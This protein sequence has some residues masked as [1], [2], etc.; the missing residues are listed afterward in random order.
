[1]LVE[2][3]LVFFVEKEKE[4]EMGKE[5][6]VKRLEVVWSKIVEGCVVKMLNELV[7]LE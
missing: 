3:I 6:L 1:M 4:I 5:D 7:L 2:E